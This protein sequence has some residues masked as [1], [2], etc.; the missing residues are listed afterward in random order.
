MDANRRPAAQQ[1]FIEDELL[2]VPMLAGQVLDAT[3]ES[4]R[5]GAPSASPHERMI[6]AD[7][8]RSVLAQRARLVDR[9]ADSVRA[10][11]IPAQD[12]ASRAAALQPV[13]ATLALLDE[14]EV[15]ADVEVSRAIEAI[16]SVAE[17]ELRELATFTSALVGDMDLRSDH[18]PFGAETYAKALW[19]ASL[20]LPVA[21][22]FQLM[23]MRSASAPLAQLLRKAYAGACSRLESAGVEPAVYR[24]VILPAGARATRPGESWLG[25]GPDLN[26]LRETMPA[27]LTERRDPGSS[28]MPLDK[29]FSDAD[30]ALRALPADAPLAERSRLL[31][32]QRSRIARHTDKVVDQ[33]LIELLS[34]LFD[35]IVADSRV[36][37]DV[38]VSLS[39]LQPAVMRL[40]LRDPGLLDNYAHPAWRFMDEIAHQAS[41]LPPDSQVRSAA[42][43][44]VEQLIDGLAREVAPDARCYRKALDDLAAASHR[45]LEARVQR[46]G[47]DLAALETLERR[48]SE[49]SEPLATGVGPLDETQLDTV[50]A[51]LMDDLKSP[52]ASAQDAAAWLN[53]RRPGDWVRL[54]QQ[55]QWIRAQLLWQGPLGDAWL[56]GR[57]SGD[58]TCALRRRALER[59]YNEG[60]VSSVL[61]RSLAKSAAVQLARQAQGPSGR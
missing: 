12:R 61:P 19:D 33:Q 7:L 57:V 50:P 20:D 1:R 4:L 26:Q 3:L 41:L 15:A 56:F 39:R 60:L 18:N 44:G 14:A 17:H 48:L 34:R 24:T 32:A 42:I 53:E 30:Q 35:A 22:G 5:T 45:R 51:D 58:A 29:L 38:Q 25:R 21:R 46:A 31:S 40:A 52:G 37:R 28:Q 43:A 47:P 13:R 54:F 55:G 8:A 36:G 11:V 16:Q 10:Q 23:F 2:R 59:L 9:F 27:P 6:V 49:R